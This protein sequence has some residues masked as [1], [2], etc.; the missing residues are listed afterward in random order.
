MLPEYP[1]GSFKCL[2]EFTDGRFLD[3]ILYLFSANVR[4]EN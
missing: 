3:L 1:F 4:L 2:S